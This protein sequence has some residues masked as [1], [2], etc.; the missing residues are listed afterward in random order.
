M[1]RKKLGNLLLSLDSVL[2]CIEMQISVI[3]LKL[4]HM[5]LKIKKTKQLKDLIFQQ[6]LKNQD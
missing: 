2:L 3:Q 1:Q 4:I 5:K 6:T